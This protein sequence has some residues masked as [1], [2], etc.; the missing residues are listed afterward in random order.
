LKG[1]DE[2]D[3]CCRDT[4]RTEYHVGMA[5]I[6]TIPGGAAV[7]VMPTRSSV[8]AHRST[9]DELN[10]LAIECRDA[11]WDGHDALPVTP[12]HV[13]GA[14]QV[15]D[16]IPADLPSP[17]VGA[18]PDGQITL[19]WYANPQR[20]VSVSVDPKGWLH[21][22]GMQDAIPFSGCLR[23]DPDLFPAELVQRIRAVGA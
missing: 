19:E 20:L 11:N 23:D 3:E 9:H 8:V 17:T 6:S 14:R 22:A 4:T 15:I 2:T 7:G 5:T 1:G 21:F 12:R 10:A 16:R 13:Q 18:D